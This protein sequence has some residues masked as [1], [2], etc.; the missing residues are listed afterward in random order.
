MRIFLI[1]L[2]SYILVACGGGG[3]STPNPTPNPTP[4][5]R[6]PVLSAEASYSVAENT[7]QVASLS[8]N[9]ADGD[10]LTWS[11][12]GT[13]ADLFSL[14]SSGSLAFNTAPNYESPPMAIP[15]TVMTLPLLS[16]MAL[17]QTRKIFRSM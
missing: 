15:I 8:G 6:A 1:F 3:S 13:D 7:T 16:V 11:L 2:A 9:D 14:S 17:C 5:N 10:S 12:G 4:S